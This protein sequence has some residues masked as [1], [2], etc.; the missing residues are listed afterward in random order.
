[1]RQRNIREMKREKN[2]YQDEHHQW[3]I[4]FKGN[5]LKVSRRGGKINEFHVPFPPD[6]VSQLEE[7]LTY[8]RPRFPPNADNLPYIFITREGV[9]F[10]QRAL[11]AALVQTVAQR[12]G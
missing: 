8:Y 1:M 9:P 10:T 4:Y 7:Y 3:H 11:Y 5:E 2:L 12:S 6:L